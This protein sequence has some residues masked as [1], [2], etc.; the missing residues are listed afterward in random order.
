MSLLAQ[1]EE[2]GLD[3]GHPVAVVIVNQAYLSRFSK[4]AG[5][6]LAEAADHLADDL[7]EGLCF[8]EDCRVL[9]IATSF[10]QSNA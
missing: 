3:S 10:R 8:D 6:R 7:Q 2:A 9:A 1:L 5:V 4:L